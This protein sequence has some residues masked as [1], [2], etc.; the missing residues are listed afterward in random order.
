AACFAQAAFALPGLTESQ[1]QQLATADDESATIDGPA[2]YP[3]LENVTQ[4]RH[5]D[6]SGATVPDFAAI[7]ADPAA[8]RG[9]VFLIEGQV[10]GPVVPIPTLRPG[11][12]GETIEQ[13]TI[14]HGPDW[15]DVV[16][17]YVAQPAEDVL[18]R[19]RVRMPAR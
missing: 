14:K 9:Q 19:T 12:W 1:T 6:E 18:P 17:V 7:E 5:G 8:H 10:A 2:L 13:W 15:D 4:W 11:P 3:L 16:V